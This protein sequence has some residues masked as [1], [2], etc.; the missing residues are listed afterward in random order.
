MQTHDV[1]LTH[2]RTHTCIHRHRPAAQPKNGTKAPDCMYDC[3]LQTLEQMLIL[4]GSWRHTTASPEAQQQM[5][6]ALGRL[7]PAVQLGAIPRSRCVHCDKLYGRHVAHNTAEKQ[8]I[9]NYKPYPDQ[10]TCAGA[11]PATDTRW[12]ITTMYHIRTA[13]GPLSRSHNTCQILCTD[14]STEAC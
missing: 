4:M 9:G 2:T 7:A 10:D 8:H 3:R 13:M 12:V 6:P 5:A 14:A 1:S 11:Q